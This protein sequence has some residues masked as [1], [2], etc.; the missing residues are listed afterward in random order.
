MAHMTHTV[1]GTALTSGA[2][3]TLPDDLIRA[4]YRIG[5]AIL[6][7]TAARELQPLLL[8]F[9]AS[10]LKRVAYHFAGFVETHRAE[11]AA[12]AD[13]TSSNIW[14]VACALDAFVASGAQ[15][16]PRALPFLYVCA[17]DGLL[18]VSEHYDGCD[19]TALTILYLATDVT[20][21][22]LSEDVH[23]APS[24]I[25]S[26]ISSHIERLWLA[27]PPGPTDDF[28]FDRTADFPLVE[29]RRFR[30]LKRSVLAPT[31]QATQ[32]PE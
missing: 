18:D 31:A 7:Q 30:M 28:P 16:V 3:P 10:R 19:I 9:M 12:D 5:D 17:L 1:R 27:L 29:L 32:T 25:S 20:L 6:V 15:D 11:R 26:H 23:L 14:Q 22:E 2:Q 21:A 4:L 24:T 13:Y 8:R